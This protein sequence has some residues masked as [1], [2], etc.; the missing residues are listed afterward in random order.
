VL[1]RAHDER[2]AGESTS[3]MLKAVKLPSESEGVDDGAPIADTAQQPV[4]RPGAYCTRHQ[5]FAAIGCE[6]AANGGRGK[7]VAAE[8]AASASGSGDRC[9]DSIKAILPRAKTQFLT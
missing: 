3:R 4:G 8:D 7:P 5:L 2:F 6:R 1:E 9:F